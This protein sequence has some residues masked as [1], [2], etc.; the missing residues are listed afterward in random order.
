MLPPLL[1]LEQTPWAYRVH[2]QERRTPGNGT[3][4]GSPKIDSCLVGHRALIML[5]NRSETVQSRRRL[6]T[7]AFSLPHKWD[8]SAEEC[9]PCS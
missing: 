3:L 7:I 6:P 5:R 2:A 8:L 4:A 1:P 9:L